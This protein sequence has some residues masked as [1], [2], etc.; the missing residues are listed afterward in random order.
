MTTTR[1]DRRRGGDGTTHRALA[2]SFLLMV[3]L[4]ALLFVHSPG[5][6][7]VSIWRAWTGNVHELGIVEGYR[8]NDSDYPPFAVVILAAVVPLGKSLHIG[9][10]LAF[11]LLLLAGLYLT[12]L[13]FL[14]LSREVVLTG[15]LQLALILSVG[16]GYID[17]FFAPTF[18]FAFLCLQA[19]W[20]AV[21][22]TAL[23][24]ACLTKWQPLLI[25]PF[26]AA[27]L[28]AHAR[29]VHR[30]PRALAL[31]LLRQ[32]APALVVVA[33]VLAVFGA[34]MG[35]ALRTALSHPFLSGNALNV[36]WIITH[37]LHVAGP[38]RFGALE[39]GAAQFIVTSD[40]RIVLVPKLLFGIAYAAVLIVFIRREKTLTNLLVFGLNAYLA[41]FTLN[42]GVH[43]NHLF[44]VV[45][46]SFL[47]CGVSD[48]Y[49]NVALIIALA[50]NVNLLLFN[51]LDGK[52]MPYS[53]VVGVDTAL[54][55]AP[56]Y[57]IV[58]A[59]VFWHT[60]WP[61][62]RKPVITPPS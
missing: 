17:V 31:A 30:S 35:Q 19:R 29:A 48:R 16:H 6:T 11:K 41:Y 23:V 34:A 7:D 27:Y 12:S 15:L 52:G 4:T 37:L 57:V 53:R 9:S 10:F 43:E 59:L 5:T 49:R 50:A 62:C 22:A 42:T 3:C 24:V 51:G 58:F 14:L 46:L 18:L 55:L 8:A 20:N 13:V 26:V 56:T 2:W 36:C 44:L 60:A 32:W 1:L 54:L 47:L 21:A 38:D 61:L 40:P 33:V 45:L 39:G 25:V 28:F